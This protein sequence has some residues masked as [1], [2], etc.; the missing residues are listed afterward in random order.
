[1]EN[2]SDTLDWLSLISKYQ[3]SEINK[4]DQDFIV[5]SDNQILE[6]YL[7]NEMSKHESKQIWKERE[8]NIC[9]SVTS[10]YKQTA[11]EEDGSLHLGNANFY[12][13]PQKPEVYL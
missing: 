5:Y 2:G 3:K 12:F 13:L 7:I 4:D 10:F 11:I 6:S 8:E 9:N 1:M